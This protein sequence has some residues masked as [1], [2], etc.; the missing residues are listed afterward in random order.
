MT[1]DELLKDKAIKPKEKTEAISK[2]ILDKSLPVDELIAFADKQKDPSKATC[3]EAMEYATKQSPNIAHE[4]VL[5]FVTNTLTAKAPRIKW[6]SAKV[7]GN[8]AH[9]FPTKLEKSINNQL[10]NTE[11]EGTV[12]RWSAAFA[13]GEILKLKTKYNK[14][15]FPAIEAICVKEEK[16]SIKKIF[17]DAIKKTKK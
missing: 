13:L 4:T 10:T 8:I 15:L 14:D 17:L 12:V 11:H 3:I 7:I 9:L 1:I 2:W 5:T 6:E 16:N